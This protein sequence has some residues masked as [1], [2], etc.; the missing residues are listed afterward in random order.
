MLLLASQ[1]PRRAELLRQIGLDFKCLP[2]DIDETPLAGESPEDY[3]RRMATEKARAM[4][5]RHP[6]D[7]VIGSD[8][9]V[10][11]HNRV[12]GKPVDRKDGI[13]MLLAL[14]G[15]TH[16]VLTGVA[17][18]HDRVDYVL[19]QSEV[20]FRTV[21]EDEAGRYWDSGEPR[22]KAGGYAIQGLGAVFVQHIQGSYSGIMGLP[23]YET[24]QLL[25]G[26]ALKLP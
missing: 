12:L 7:A 13:D 21:S 6:G 22:D 24:A 14:S 18:V 9:T 10:V 23:L 4:H 8:T 26:I 20:S 15:Q 3:V 2:A 16:R 19:S 5:A 1:S 11:L 25:R 17:L